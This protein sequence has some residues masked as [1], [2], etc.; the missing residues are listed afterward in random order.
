MSALPGTTSANPNL[1]ASDQ[2]GGMA[3]HDGVVVVSL[4]ALN[5]LVFIRATDGTIIGQADVPSPRGLAFDSQGRLLALS[6][7]RLLRF[8]SIEDPAKL[9]PGR[10]LVSAGLEQPIAVTLDGR[11]RIYVSD[12]GQ[13]H[14]VKIFSVDGRP[15]G[16]IGKSGVP[17]AGP[18]DPLRMQNPAGITIDSKNQL[19]VTEEDF[20][21]KRVSVWTLDGRWVNAFYGPGKY[22]GGGTLDSKDKTTFYYADEGHGA[23][24]FKLDWTKGSYELTNVYYR[25][26]PDDLKLA[27]RSAAPESVIYHQGRRYFTNG[28][29]SSPTNG[30]N[31]AFLFIERDGVA[32]PVAAMGRASEWD[33][34]KGDA[35]RPLW[36]ANLDLASDKPDQNRA[37]FIWNDLNADA[38]VQPDEVFL[39]KADGSGV[40]ILDDLSFCLAR[41]DGKTTRFAPVAIDTRGNP[42]YDFAKAE[43]L[44]TGV[45]DPASSGGNQALVTADGWTAVTLGIEPFSKYSVSGAKNGVAK[46]GY[47]NLWPGLHASHESPPPEY[48][49]EL[50]GPTRLLGGLMNS[51]IGPLWAINSNQGCF[52]I[53]TADGLFVATVFEDTRQGKRWNMPRA[54]RGMSLE[55]LTLNDENF[56]PTLTQ[57]PD[58][59]VYLVDG[60]RSSLVRIDGLNNLT[61]LPDASLNLTRKDLDRSRA[62]L[63]GIEAA[64]QQAQ[65]RGMLTIAS[66]L[67]APTVDGKLDD[68]PSTGWVDI[69]RRGVRAYFNANTKPYDVTGAVAVAGG[70]LYAAWR[71]GD[72][73]LLDNSG[74]MP[75]APFKTGGALDLMIG[76]NPNAD[77][78]RTAPVYGD[79]RLLVTLIDDKPRALIYRPLVSNAGDAPKISFA[80]PWRTINFDRVDD[81]TAQVQFAARDGNYEI[82]VPL[83]LLQLRPSAGMVIKGDIGILRGQDGQTTARV[84]WANK[85]TGITADVPSEAML[86]PDLWGNW[87]FKPEEANQ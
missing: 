63:L 34:L 48:P 45:Q 20:L 28:Y 85:A 23:M 35:F 72:P 29:N 6:G 7:T 59:T 17:K 16:T 73:K 57:L 80:S 87:L 25:P 44:A 81:V 62:Y 86:T 46:W 83:D 40:T 70:R 56:W 3:V 79:V 84:Y 36:P 43:V 74:E 42:R 12:R 50:V 52:Y 71:T 18:Y 66:R 31:T 5:Q 58:G 2:I 26:A 55:G 37:F 60:G 14:Q 13:S 21:P 64:R 24:E 30:H 77:P 15:A 69:D 41:L 38:Q 54:V 68:W 10:P 78:A 4:T 47:P 51:R 53:F 33:V 19:W 11:G 76:A 75:T 27:F 65:G 82:S 61:R 8:D 49:G 22:G 67:T 9:G 1:T 39:T 32:R